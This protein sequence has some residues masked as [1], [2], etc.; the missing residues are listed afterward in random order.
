MTLHPFDVC[1]PTRSFCPLALHSLSNTGWSRVNMV[2]PAM[3]LLL[4]ATLLLALFVAWSTALLCPTLPADYAANISTHDSFVT[5][6][7]RT[8]SY[9]VYLPPAYPATVSQPVESAGAFPL[10]LLLH[11]GL[12]T[13]AEAQAWYA[14]NAQAALHSF[15]VVYPQGLGV[16][17]VNTSWNAGGGCCGEIAATGVDDVLF[18]S[19]LVQRLA[20]T[21]CLD[22]RAFFA[23]GI[24]DGAIMAQRLGCDAGFSPL[25]AAIAPVEGTLPPRPFVCDATTALSVL[26]VHGTND[27]NIPF[28][29]GIG[30]GRSGTSFTSVSSTLSTWTAKQRCVQ[31]YN[32][33]T[34]PNSM[35]LDAT[36]YSFGPCEGPVIRQPPVKSN[37]SVVL[38]LIQGGGHTWSG[39]GPQPNGANCSA[40][41]G[42]W[43]ASEHIWSFLDA[44]RRPSSGG[45]SDSGSSTGG[46]A[47]SGSTTSGSSSSSNSS[48]SG[49]PSSSRSDISFPSSSATLSASSADRL[50]LGVVHTLYACLLGVISTVQLFAY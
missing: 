3:H 28:G 12:S 32:L 8:R 50:R 36:L 20:A 9:I 1:C 35:E 5:P 40:A 23:A 43:P 19:L 13:A 38:A 31:P 29:G 46:G 47:A 49:G 48:S 14:M 7:N 22:P 27:T 15:V 16:A 30:C 45:G 17:S 44:H 39:A 42:D 21:L 37:T 33:T 6:D 11:P 41:V 34:A 4:L 26:E 2:V 25:L 10:V 18:I 24:S